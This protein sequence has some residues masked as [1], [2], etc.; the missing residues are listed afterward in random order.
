[1]IL[2]STPP[3][4]TTGT[5]TLPSSS[6]GVTD[7]IAGRFARVLSVSVARSSP[8]P[9]AAT[10]PGAAPDDDDDDDDGGGV[11]VIAPLAQQEGSSEEPAPPSSTNDA[12]PDA[13]AQKEGSSEEPAPPSSTNDAAPDAAE[14]LSGDRPIPLPDGPPAVARLAFWPSLDV[15]RRE[16]LPGLPK[17]E[18][19]DLEDD[20]AISVRGIPLGPRRNLGKRGRASRPALDCSDRL[21]GAG[22]GDGGRIGDAPLV[23]PRESF[24]AEPP[25]RRYRCRPSKRLTRRVPPSVFVV[26]PDDDEALD[27]SGCRI[28]GFKTTTASAFT[29]PPPPPRRLRCEY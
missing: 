10:A 22:E 6:G 12:A 16:G 3:A 20:N 28:G 9:A 17:L 8:L 25:A 1:M 2:A 26:A 4:T 29:T 23:P 27:A 5:T 24:L 13:A 18:D 7:D 14:G 11:S 19:D 21:E 15:R